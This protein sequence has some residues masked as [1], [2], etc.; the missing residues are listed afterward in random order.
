MHVF[1]SSGVRGVAGE[2]LTPQDAMQVAQA[3]GSVWATDTDRVAV[4]RDTRTTGRTYGNAATAGLT[5]LGF[6]VDRLGIVPTP[7][8]QAYCEREGVPGLMVTASHN[9]PMYNGVKLVGP[10]GVEL[11]R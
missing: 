3:A 10:E 4:A 2:E 9:P 1:G 5:G 11:T 7:A 6:D 8:L